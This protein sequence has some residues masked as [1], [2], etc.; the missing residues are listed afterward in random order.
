MNMNEKSECAWMAIHTRQMLE[1]LNPDAAR[2]REAL[3]GIAKIFAM[4]L[5][6]DRLLDSELRP[7]LHAMLRE[8][9]GVIFEEET[10]AQRIAYIRDALTQAQNALTSPTEPNDE[11]GACT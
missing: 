8:L 1:H 4:G 3:R 11:G 7:F 2:E 5:I 10:D 6:A 9:T